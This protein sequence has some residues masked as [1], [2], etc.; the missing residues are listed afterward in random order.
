MVVATDPR[1]PFAYVLRE[2]RAASTN[3][4]PVTTF[5]VKPLDMLEQAH[6]R[7][8]LSIVDAAGQ[9]QIRIGTAEILRLRLGLAGWSDFFD[10]AGK[11]VPYEAEE[12]WIAGEKRSCV[13]LDCL[14]RLSPEVRSELAE[15]VEE[16]AAPTPAE[17]KT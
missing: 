10:S 7:D 11:P 15:A 9:R 12:V 14:R 4:K 3:G 16:G 17:I 1:L 2:D 6:V 5:R 8:N 13:K